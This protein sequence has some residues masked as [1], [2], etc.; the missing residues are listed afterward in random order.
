MIALSH[1]L[2]LSKVTETCL[3][4]LH[5]QLPLLSLSVFVVDGDGGIPSLP[6]LTHHDHYLLSVGS[7]L[8][9]QVISWA[10]R[11]F[12]INIFFFHI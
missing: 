6:F 12:L 10:N 11:N 3:F 4:C 8:V 7:R 9:D 5:A 1:H 2:I